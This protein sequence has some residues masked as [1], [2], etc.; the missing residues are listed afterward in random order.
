MAENKNGIRIIVWVVIILVIA[1]AAWFEYSQYSSVLKNKKIDKDE[2]FVI[3]L[4]VGDVNIKKSSSSVWSGLKE[5]DIV[6]MGDSVKTGPDSYCELQL[7]KRG[8]FRIEASSEIYISTL[9]NENNKIN[10]KTIL[11]KGII[12]LKPE[13]LKEG[14]NFEVQTSIVN[15]AVRGT[16]FSVNILSNGDTKVPWMRDRSW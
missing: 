5:S 8:V 13:K 4:V 2:A 10:S 12:A 15:A 7:V 16:R 1:A 3:S 9:I 6:Q 14:E 11:D